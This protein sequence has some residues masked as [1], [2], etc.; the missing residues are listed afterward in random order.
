MTAMAREPRSVVHDGDRRCR[1]DSGHP[2]GLRGGGAWRRVRGLGQVAA[3]ATSAAPGVAVAPV[4]VECDRGCRRDRRG[5]RVPRRR[6]RCGAGAGVDCHRP[7]CISCRLAGGGAAAR[8]AG[9][10]RRQLA[11]AGQ[12]ARARSRRHARGVVREVSLRWSPGS[13]ER[14]VGGRRARARRGARRLTSRR[15]IGR[16]LQGGDASR[17]DR[18]GGGQGRSRRVVVDAAAG[19]GRGGRTLALAAVRDDGRSRATRASGGVRRDETRA[20]RCLAGCPD[21]CVAGAGQRGA[22]LPA[23]G[24]RRGD[25]R[26]HRLLRAPGR[27]DR[28]GRRDRASRAGAHR[29]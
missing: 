17:P 13:G 10:R 28:V 15:R 22:R 29:A 21:G 5:R 12:A 6:R 9:A 11:A 20:R 3:A 19:C 23:P 18:S 26:C 27:A 14:H 1:G 24:A 25:R 4:V 8:A 2:R 7:R 16:T